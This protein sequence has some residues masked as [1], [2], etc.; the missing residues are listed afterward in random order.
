MPYIP[1]EQSVHST[2][3]DRLL[4]TVDVRGDQEYLMLYT[5]FERP[6]GA[7]MI[8]SIG[9]STQAI[10]IGSTDGDSAAGSGAGP[11][12]WD[13]FSRDLIVAKR[14]CHQFHCKACDCVLVV[15]VHLRQQFAQLS[16]IYRGTVLRPGFGQ[17]V[18]R[19][20][21]RSRVST[22]DIASNRIPK[23]LKIAEL[24]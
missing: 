23:N 22:C 6:V 10:S 18:P 24:P 16:G 4:G 12:N 14:I 21:I 1:A 11:L 20:E 7:G 8:W 13:E 9:R 19:F 3:L 5:S 2:L 17:N 15:I